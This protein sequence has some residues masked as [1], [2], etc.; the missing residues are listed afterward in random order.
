M[1]LN[2]DEDY[3]N[4]F[5][6]LSQA[7]GKAYIK[8]FLCHSTISFTGRVTYS[9]LHTNS[10]RLR[11]WSQKATRPFHL[12]TRERCS[13][14]RSQTVLKSRFALWMLDMFQWWVFLRRWLK[15]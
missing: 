9:T 13:L 12:K 1:F 8:E 15:F 10:F 6:D 2:L 4:I 7:D 14:L 5:S 11:T 3:K